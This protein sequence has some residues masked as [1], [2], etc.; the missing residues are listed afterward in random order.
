MDERSQG[1]WFDRKKQRCVEGRPVLRRTGEM[2][3]GKQQHFAS[4]PDAQ[5]GSRA[6]YV[7]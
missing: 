3:N 5:L 7:T 6:G 1:G 2:G 4:G